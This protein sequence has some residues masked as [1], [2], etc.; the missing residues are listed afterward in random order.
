MAA[1]SRGSNAT[2]LCG[3][4]AG[5]S[6]IFCDVLECLWPGFSHCIGPNLNRRTRRRGLCPFLLSMETDAVRL[7]YH[8]DATALPGDHGFQLFCA[9]SAGADEYCMG[10]HSAGSCIHVSGVSDDPLFHS[11]SLHHHG[12]GGAGRRWAFTDIL[13]FGAAVG[14]AGDFV[15]S[16]SRFSGILECAGAA[17]DISKNKMLW[18]ISLYL[19]T[20]TPENAAVSLVA[21]VMMLLPALL[22][23]LFGQNY[24]EAGIAASGTEGL[25]CML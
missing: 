10:D 22:I 9:G 15:G 2:G 8:S 12:S 21:S 19:P 4:A 24:L 25:R 3:T 7:V 20:V 13:V 17:I 14:C 1:D 5:Y 16:G 23:F 11:H 6:G 18:P